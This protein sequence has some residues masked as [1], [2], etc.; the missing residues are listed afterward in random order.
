MRAKV[1][2]M[3]RQVGNPKTFG[4]DFDP[5]SIE[6]E[7]PQNRNLLVGRETFSPIMNGHSTT[8]RTSDPINSLCPQLDLLMLQCFL[9]RALWM[10]GQ[11][12]LQT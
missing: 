1:Q 11:D 5:A 4:A 12:I 10:A 7:P 9:I 3:S 2:Y 8:F 6:I